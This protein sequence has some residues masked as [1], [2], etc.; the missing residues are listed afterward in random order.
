MPVRPRR[1]PPPPRPDAHPLSL[2]RARATPASLPLA[3]VHAEPRPPAAAR[4][5]TRLVRANCIS[6]AAAVSRAAASPTR[7]KQQSPASRHPRPGTRAHQT[8]RGAQFSSISRSAARRP[9]RPVCLLLAVAPT[10]LPLLRLPAALT[11]SLGSLCAPTR[12]PTG[13]IEMELRAD[14]VPKTA[15]AHAPSERSRPVCGGA[16]GWLHLPA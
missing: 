10:A 14:V 16:A 6:R 9:V 11:R 12:S 3:S 2:P 7:P 8:P 15:G 13:R 5:R 4:R 1:P